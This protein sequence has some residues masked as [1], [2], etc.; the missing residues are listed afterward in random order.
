MTFTR[1][2]VLTMSAAALATSGCGGSGTTATN[3]G[4]SATTTGGGSAPL[5]QIELAAHAN[6]ICK[7]MH[8]HLLK[9]N[10]GENPAQVYAQ[11]ASYEQN[12]L[13]E[14]QKLSPSAEQA[15]DWKQILATIGALAKASTAYAE[16]AKAK[17]TN[18][19][20]S[21]ANSYRPVKQRGIVAA[22]H[23]RIGECAA[24]F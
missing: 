19:A 5:S 23:N 11:A 10:G 7:R 9:L 14:L 18:S 6:A 2:A 22:A 13:A 16:Y 20:N 15:S 12:A 17:N 3:A 8:A 24:A 21:L 1:L 4:G